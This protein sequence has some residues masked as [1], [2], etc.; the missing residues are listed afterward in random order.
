MAKKKT[1]NSK[2]A[3]QAAK[4]RRTP[5]PVFR[6]WA[7]WAALVCAVA[8]G[9]LALYATNLTF[10]IAREGVQVPL[11]I[12]YVADRS[13]AFLREGNH[14]LAA[15]KPEIVITGIADPPLV[16]AISADERALI[17]TVINAQTRDDIRIQL[18]NLF[19]D[20]ASRARLEGDTSASA[21]LEGTLAFFDGAYARGKL[22]NHA[23]PGIT[24]TWPR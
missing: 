5:L 16:T 12:A 3:R 21:Y 13:E 18:K 7:F 22:L 6:T 8:G 17:F 9:A 23:A 4:A 2:R 19:K 15:A 11:E 10:S 1:K 24:F 14:R 20:A